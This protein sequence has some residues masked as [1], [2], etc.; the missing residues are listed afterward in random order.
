M[1]LIHT[2]LS[3]PDRNLHLTWNSSF[4]GVHKL[5][6]LISDSN[7]CC[8]RPTS[9]ITPCHWVHGLPASR[10]SSFSKFTTTTSWPVIYLCSF[11]YP[12]VTS[13]GPFQPT[14]LALWISQRQIHSPTCLLDFF[15]VN[16]QKHLP[17]C[18]SLP[19]PVSGNISTHTLTSTFLKPS[20][21]WELLCQHSC[22]PSNSTTATVVN[23]YLKA[24]I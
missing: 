13:T 18:G 17:S 16:I 22:S 8:P 14:A 23:S 1:P 20:T 19:L 15:M 10:P 3:R 6:R 7:L 21:A 24:I 9:S 4:P 12:C 2:L 5:T 11:S